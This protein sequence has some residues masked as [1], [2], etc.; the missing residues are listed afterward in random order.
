MDVPGPESEQDTGGRSSLI[1]LNAGFRAIADVGSKVATAVLYLLVARK[2]G[3]AQFGVFAFALSFAGIAVTLGYFGQEVVLVREVSRDRGKLDHYYSNVLTSKVVLSLPPLLAA[4]AVAFALGMSFHTL[5]VV[6][7]MGLG[8]IFD[9]V[10]GVSFSV[11]LAYERVSLIPV[12]LI[13]QRWLTTLVATVVL[14]LGAGILAVAA[15]YCTGALLAA[16][17]AAWVL[18]RRIAHPHLRFDLRGA[19][20]VA[21]D[22]APVGVGIVALLLLTRIDTTMLAIFS[23]SSEVGQYGAAYRLLE[24]TA[25]VTWSVNTAVLPAMSRLTPTTTPPVGFLY[26]RAVKLVLALTVPAAAGAAILATPIIALLYGS[27]YHRA[28]EALLLL[29][30]TI[31]LFP[32]SSLSC[33]LFYSQDVRHVV[34]TIYAVVL[35]ENIVWNLIMIPR[36]SLYGA[37]AGTSVSELLVSGTLLFCS[38]GLHGRLNIRR[39]LAGVL[40]GTAGAGALMALFSHSLL[41]AIPLGVAS[42]FA[43]FLTFER[44]AFPDDFATVTDL[45]ARVK[46]SGP[47]ASPASQHN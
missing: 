8:F 19:L 10:I 45:I 38:R 40:L 42:Y 16:I 47:L 5:M 3:A 22:A 29:S 6:L 4:V 26:G 7:L 9:C 32:I 28:A 33:Q 30:P 24:T 39:I 31:M 23:S 2:T 14:F 15:I 43:I 12:V 34:V 44:M 21:R 25:F 41:L 46:G 20:A 13:A 1:L 36:F 11:F 37:A 18:F 17:F 35:L 27:E